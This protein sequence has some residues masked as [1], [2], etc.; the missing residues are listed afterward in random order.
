[1]SGINTEANP[2]G[3]QMTGNL[4]FNLNIIKRGFTSRVGD[5]APAYRSLKTFGFMYSIIYGLT[6]QGPLSKVIT[7]FINVIMRLSPRWLSI[8]RQ[9]LL[10]N[11]CTYLE[12][13][14]L[15]TASFLAVIFK[16]VRYSCIFANSLVVRKFWTDCKCCI[17]LI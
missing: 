5:Y 1:M 12:F 14:H 17:I 9:S 16:R 3:R 7:L 4:L 8:N 6:I 13:N 15:D 10:Y 11:K 2:E